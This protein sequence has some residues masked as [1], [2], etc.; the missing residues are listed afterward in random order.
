MGKHGSARAVLVVAAIVALAGCTGVGTA[1]APDV[2]GQG[3]GSSSTAATSPASSA[4]QGSGRQSAT[5]TPG[6]RQ[7]ETSQSFVQADSIPFPVAVGN[8][9]VYRTTVGDQT[10]RTTNSIVSAGPG[11]AGYEVTMSSTTDVAGTATAAQPV[12]LF[13]PD[14]TIGYPVPPIN[15]VS[16]AGGSIRW[17]DVAGLASGRAYHSVV[18]ILDSQTGQYQNANVTVRGEGTTS[19]SVPAG[20]YQAS[21]VDTVIAAKIGGSITTVEVD[22][23]I[24]QGTGPVQTAVLIQA[25]GKIELTTTNVLLSFTKGAVPGIGS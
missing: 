3:V 7:R 2:P 12:Y 14:G 17:P 11:A 19:V 6:A 15:G 8:T 5:S 24:A 18:R 9:W 22:S 20:T 1:T 23:W 16:V 21:V 10:G 4:A 13:Y 25:A